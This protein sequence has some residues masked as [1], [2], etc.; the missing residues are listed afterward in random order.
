MKCRVM[1]ARRGTCLSRKLSVAWGFV[2]LM[3]RKNDHA[4]GSRTASRA[5]DEGESVRCRV[6]AAGRGTAA[7]EVQSR[8][9]LRMRGWDF[10]APNSPAARHSGMS[11][12]TTS[13]SA[14]P[15]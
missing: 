4:P 6:A 13:G 14:R 9:S 5:H 10:V 15:K 1:S 11:R 7:A 8:E 3:A 2:I 12:R